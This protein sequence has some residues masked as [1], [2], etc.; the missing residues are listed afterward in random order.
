[1]LL[2]HQLILKMHFTR[3]QRLHI[4]RSYLKFFLQMSILSLHAC[5]M[6][7]VLPWE[8]LQRSRKYHFQYSGFR[9]IPQVVYVDNSYLQGD[10][11]E[12]SLKNVN[13]T[14]IMLRSLGFTIHPE[15]SVLKPT[16]N[17][18][19]LS[20]IINSKDMTLKLTEERKKIMT[21]YQTFWKIKTHN[22]ICSTGIWQYS[23]YLPSCA[24]RT[25]N[26]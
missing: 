6:G 22:T 5:Q 8:S 13:D 18:I 26:L 3:C 2:L 9:A 19:Y 14:I 11:Y 25:I 17:L 7:M 1:M 12:S 10:S 4:I 16:Q 24:T 23:C 20:F 15:K 21:L